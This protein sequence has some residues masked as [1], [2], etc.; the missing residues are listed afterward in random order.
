MKRIIT[1]LLT[2]SVIFTLASCKKPASPA[3]AVSAIVDAET[4]RPAGKLYR[5]SSSE[6][7]NGYV[8]DLM[9]ADVY[10]FDRSLKGLEDGAIW[11]SESF[12]PFEAAVFLCG[13]YRS[14]EDIALSL[15]NR[16]RTLQMNASEASAFCE[17]T[18]TEYKSYV[19]RGI[20]IISGELVAFIISSDPEAAKKAFL[21]TASSYQ[22]F[23]AIFSSAS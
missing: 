11:L 7:E 19:D 14:A 23:S 20:V 6:G 2:I 17:M 22:I 12:H 4:G 9:I 18:D 16:L 8:S 13:D 15:K 10:G 21:N 5:L 1:T 3:E